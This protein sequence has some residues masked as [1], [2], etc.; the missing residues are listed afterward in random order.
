MKVEEKLS[1]EQYWN[2]KRF[3]S[4]KFDS[5]SLIGKNGD[6]IYEPLL[7]GEWKQ[8]PSFHTVP[9]FSRHENEKNKRRDLSGINVLVSRKFV[10]FGQA[11]IS[12]PQDLA[13]C[14]PTARGHK[15]N[16][17]HAAVEKWESFIENILTRQSGMIA[18]P[19]DFPKINE[20]NFE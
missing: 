15:C 2:D 11:A 17:P 14:L 13:G 18:Y 16:F 20:N 1:F 3:E 8:H 7:S 6:N 5:G 19:I 9:R 4:K 12:L 10:Y